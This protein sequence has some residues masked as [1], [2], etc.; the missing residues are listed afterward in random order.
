MFIWDQKKCSL[1]PSVL[2]NRVRY[3]RVLLY[4]FSSSDLFKQTFF[5]FLGLDIYPDVGVDFTEDMTFSGVNGNAGESLPMVDRS[6]A[7]SL[8]IRVKPPSSCGG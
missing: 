1:K 8:E 3:K 4:M 5:P 7:S 2:Y 6:R